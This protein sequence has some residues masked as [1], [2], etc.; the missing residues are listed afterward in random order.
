MRHLGEAYPVTSVS[1]RSNSPFS[2][3][4]GVGRMNAVATIA[5]S[6]KAALD[7][8]RNTFAAQ[9]ITAAVVSSTVSQNRAFEGLIRHVPPRVVADGV[10]HALSIL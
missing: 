5:V 6:I 9:A 4:I 7:T 10:E 3:E 8:N 2:A 1:A